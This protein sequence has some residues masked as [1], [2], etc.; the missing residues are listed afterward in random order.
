M[1][2]S[3]EELHNINQNSN[4]KVLMLFYFLSVGPCLPTLNSMSKWILDNGS[5][6]ASKGVFE[7]N[8]DSSTMDLVKISYRQSWQNLCS[9]Y[10]S[11]GIGG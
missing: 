3:R 10:M 4:S 8:M 9:Q 6:A 7:G 5:Q 11:N 2:L 1:R